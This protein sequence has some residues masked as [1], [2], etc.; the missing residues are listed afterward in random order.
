MP[1]TVQEVSLEVNK[2][3]GMAAFAI[4]AVVV[5]AVS[6]IS[7]Y[8][9]NNSLS[10]GETTVVNSFLFLTHTRNLGG[11][12]GSFQ[13]MGWAFAL[14]SSCV[15]SGVL[16]YLLLGPAVRFYEYICFACIVGAGASNV[17]DR[18]IYGGVIDFI[19]IQHIPYWNYIFNTAD[20]MIH[21]GL[22]SMLLFSL[23]WGT[24]KTN[25]AENI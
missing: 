21:I 22:W 19:D 5:L 2:I 17:I 20:V 1:G 4:I 3:K 23:F 24:R 18:F 6:Q 7:S 16:L 11:V 8:V 25:L 9:I 12:F 10:I 14:F 13:G 15:L